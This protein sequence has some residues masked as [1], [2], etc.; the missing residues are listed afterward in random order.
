MPFYLTRGRRLDAIL[1]Q[2]DRA[3]D[4]AQQRSEAA[5]DDDMT[6]VYHL[7]TAYHERL[8]ELRTAQGVE[9]A[10]LAARADQ[11]NGVD[12]VAE[13]EIEAHLTALAAEREEFEAEREQQLDD[14]PELELGR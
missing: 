6:V 1:N 11:R 2:A 14:E 9:F 3:A 12:P 10:E 8:H 4:A 13:A 5:G 7:T